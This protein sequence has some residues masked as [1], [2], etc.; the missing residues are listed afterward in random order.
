MPSR[1]VWLWWILSLFPDWSNHPSIWLFPSPAWVNTF[2]SGWRECSGSLCASLC[3]CTPC[4]RCAS[5]GCC[6]T[7]QLCPP[8]TEG[9]GC[10]GPGTSL[11]ATCNSLCPYNSFLAGKHQR[12]NLGFPPWDKFVPS[13][14]PPPPRL[15]TLH[16]W[17][18]PGLNWFSV[19]ILQGITAI[20]NLSR[21]KR[22]FSLSTLQHFAGITWPDKLALHL[23][24]IRRWPLNPTRLPTPN[25]AWPHSSFQGKLEMHPREKPQYESAL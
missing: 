16:T 18:P 25:K 13:P 2:I 23:F 4:G 11:V 17:R 24:A 6:K 21:N 14:P 9:L 15:P 12:P 1:K 3:G 19:H 5:P 10:G 20:C 7:R 22:D 8:L